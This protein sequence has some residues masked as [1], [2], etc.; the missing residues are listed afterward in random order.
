MSLFTNCHFW[1]TRVSFGSEWA[2]IVGGQFFKG[3]VGK[4]FDQNPAGKKI[5]CSSHHIAGS[6]SRQVRH[7]ACSGFN[8][9]LQRLFVCVGSAVFLVAFLRQI[10]DSALALI[11]ARIDL[12]L[13]AK[14][15]AEL[16]SYAQ[17]LI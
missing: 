8:Q 3:C 11:V 7:S 5:E 17:A 4:L 14:L 2:T 13:V 12:A 10:N 9:L 16:H 15:G 1:V 6:T